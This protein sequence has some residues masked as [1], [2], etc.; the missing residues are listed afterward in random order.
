MA[1]EVRLTSSADATL[2][3]FELRHK[4]TFSELAAAAKAVLRFEPVEMICEEVPFNAQVN[5][6]VAEVWSL[7]PGH[8]NPSTKEWMGVVIVAVRKT[9]DG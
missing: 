5:A 9:I 6:T 8:V 1:T 7:F 4:W 3:P 2:R